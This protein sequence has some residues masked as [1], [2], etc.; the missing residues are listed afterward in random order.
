MR[1]SARECERVR[2]RGQA[3]RAVDKAIKSV[4]VANGARRRQRQTATLQRYLSGDK[5]CN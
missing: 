5:E 1:E 3:C 2:E 4:G